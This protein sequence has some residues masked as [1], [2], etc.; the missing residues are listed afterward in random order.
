MPDCGIPEYRYYPPL[1]NSF[2]I[3]DVNKQIKGF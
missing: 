2:A 3:V 1:G